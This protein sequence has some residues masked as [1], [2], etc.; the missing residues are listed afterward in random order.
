MHYYFNSGENDFD[1]VFAISH[2][3]YKFIYILLC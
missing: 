1:Y 2:E 3:F